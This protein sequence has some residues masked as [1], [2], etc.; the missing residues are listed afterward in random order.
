MKTGPSA[1]PRTLASLPERDDRPAVVEPGRG[2]LTYRDLDQLA[3]AVAAR[4]RRLGVKPGARV[5]L[6]LRR[7]SDTIAAMLGI[8]RADCVYVPVDT[9][10]PVPR[11][12]ATH[13]DCGV[14]TTFIEERF[15]SLYRQEIAR[16]GA[17][18]ISIQRLSLAGPGEAISNWATAGNGSEDIDAANAIATHAELACILYTS[19]T[20]G[21]PKGWMM[22]RTA[23]EAHASWC[24]RLLAPTRADVFA[25]HAQFSFGMSLFD[26]Y[27]SLG[28]G[29]PIVLVPDEV[30][31]H[32]S[33]LVELIA[34][35]RVSIWFS[36]PAALSL[37][38]QSDEL[39]RQDLSALRIIAFAGEVFPGNRLEPLRA[40]V[41]HPAYFNFYGSTETNVAAYYELPRD[42]EFQAPPPIGYPCGHYEA[43]IRGEN[44]ATVP[45]GAVGELQLRG[46][47]LNTG[48]WNQP[49]LT[50]EKTAP[51]DDGG[52]PWFRTGDLV[53]QLPTGA[54][55]YTGRIGRML[56]LRGYRVEPG[57]I[58]ARLY[59]HPS[60]REAAVVPKRRGDDLEL[61]AHLS[62]STQQPIPTIQLK[63][64]CAVRL[65]PYM[66]PARF[67]F[68]PTL[69]R[70]SRGKI[71][72]QK[73]AE[74][75]VTPS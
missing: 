5:G 57:E 46:A 69:P 25:N 29:A 72:L 60:I 50:A 18:G 35:E 11:T 53:T 70:T 4:L 16:C 65:P 40:R 73:L 52:A 44:G 10:A 8:L 24:H 68:H 17:T 2:V 48:Y 27:S 58:E 61:V 21:H 71:D 67:G 62:T 39:E 30:R 43:R 1:I 14:Q 34:R 55:S 56:K 36:A 74:D 54:L 26:I 38:G 59:E 41:R 63:E 28:C 9:R 31:Q 75:D 12:V 47:G 64:F 6:Y 15:E 49:E 66:I 42:T 45:L 7:S 37:I 23:I 51:A 32:A 33:R 19:G 3:D 13:L 22:S 20:T